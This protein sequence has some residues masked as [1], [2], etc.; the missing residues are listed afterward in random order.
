MLAGGNLDEQGSKRAIETILRN[1]RAQRQLIDD[2]LDISRIISGKLRLEMRPIELAPMIEAVVDGVRPAAD[3]RN[4]HLQTALDSLISPVSGDPDRIQQIVWNLLSNAIKF[5]PE[6]GSVAVRLVR[7]HTHIEIT[8]SDTG[9]GIDPELLLHVFDRFRQADSSITRRHGGLGLGLS[10]VRQL[11]EMH[12]GTVTAESPGTGEG[13]V[14]KVILPLMS[15]HHE[16]SDPETA[17]PLIVATTR[18]DREPSLND[19]RVLVVDDEPDARELVAAVLT[20]SGAEVVS[21][22]SADE[23]LAKMAQQQFDVLVSD[24]GM[25]K[26]DGYALI[27]KVRQLSVERGGR[28]PAAALT[29]YAGIEDRRRVLA[30]GYQMHIPK[31]V[32]PAE[33]TSAVAGLAEPVA[34]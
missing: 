1:A 25:P 21:V 3:A 23:A 10:I 26:M 34:I 13:T 7:V 32:E 33:L 6:G 9:Q 27:S 19:L 31:P 11:V 5:T 29:A 4:I 12:G 15:V 2:L 20:L 24:I 18:T 16:L 28:I 14:F 22:G 8:I 30:S 17:R